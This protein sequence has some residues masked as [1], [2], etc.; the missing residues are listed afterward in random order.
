MLN[1]IDPIT[2]TV[3]NAQFRDSLADWFYIARVA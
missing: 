1:K 2:G 3:I